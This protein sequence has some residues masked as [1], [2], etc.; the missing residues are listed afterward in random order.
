MKFMSAQ[1]GGAGECGKERLLASH[2]QNYQDYNW[3]KNR[4]KKLD[5]Y[6]QTSWLKNL[7]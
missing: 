5:G 7:K 6:H 4:D 1:F 3:N 2:C